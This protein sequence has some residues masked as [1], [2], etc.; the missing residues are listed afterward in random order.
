MS[1]TKKRYTIQ[2]E[3]Q[4]FRSAEVTVWASS[5][6]EAALMARRDAYQGEITMAY[7]A[8]RITPTIFSIV[9]GDLPYTSGANERCLCDNI[10]KL[11][12]L[13]GLPRKMANEFDEYADD[14][15][16]TGYEGR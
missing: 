11:L 1:N 2:V 15:D 9:G 13:E 6:A 8:H 4:I 5:A 14:T 7:Q 16:E 10:K 3:D 12:E